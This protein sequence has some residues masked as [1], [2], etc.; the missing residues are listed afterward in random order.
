VELDAAL[1]LSDKWIWTNA[2]ISSNKSK[3]LLKEMEFCKFRNTDIAFL[4]TL[5]SKKWTDL[6]AIKKQYSYFFK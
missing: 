6:F 2:T 5:Y 4:Q 1:Y 3:I